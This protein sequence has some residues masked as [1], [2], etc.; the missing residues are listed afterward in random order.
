M[1]FDHLGAEA[2]DAAGALDLARETFERLYERRPRVQLAV[3]DQAAAELRAAE[4]RHGE[5]QRKL[6]Q[7]HR[8]AAEL[9]PRP[10]CGLC[11]SRRGRDS[12]AA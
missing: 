10:R 11:Q 3:L 7:H 6:E 2:H 12:E 9:R 5:A 8:A 4:C 1:S